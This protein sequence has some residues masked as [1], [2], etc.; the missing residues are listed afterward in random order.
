MAATAARSSDGELPTARNGPSDEPSHAPSQTP[1]TA[2]EATQ[3]QVQPGTEPQLRS[4]RHRVTLTGWTSFEILEVATPTDHVT[5]DSSFPTALTKA[6]LNTHLDDRKPELAASRA[7]EKKAAI[8]VEGERPPSTFLA[9]W[10]NPMRQNRRQWHLDQRIQ[11]GKPYDK[12]TFSDPDSLKVSHQRYSR[13]PL[14]SRR[15]YPLAVSGRRDGGMKQGVLTCVSFMYQKHGN[16]LKGEQFRSLSHA[17]I[18]T[19]NRPGY[20]EFL[21]SILCLLSRFKKF[22]IRILY[23][24]SSRSTTS[25][26]SRVQASCPAFVVLS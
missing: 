5:S 6:F 22:S 16:E 23:V 13:L 9:R 1:R 7:Y 26:W 3:S 8:I 2:P 10:T 12:D 18:I 17:T 4:T 11:M 21:W 25:E 14:D 15:S 20:K 24:L 19:A